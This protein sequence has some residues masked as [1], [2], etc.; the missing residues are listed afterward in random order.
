MAQSCLTLCDP[1]DWSTPGFPVLH[2][3]LE[4]TQ[5]HVHRV[6]DVIQPSYPL[7]SPS[8]A[9]N[10]PS[11]MDF[12][13]ES[14]LHVSILPHHCT[15]VSWLLLLCFCISLPSVIRNYFKLLFGTRGTSRKLNETY[16]LQRRNKGKDLYPGEP[17]RV[18]LGFPVFVEH[19]RHVSADINYWFWWCLVYLC[20]LCVWNKQAS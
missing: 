19:V 18:L 4:L 14:V 11:I 13:S 7:S 9:F 5:N 1:M 17:H 2:Q 12:P 20:I 3:L 6:G 16:F 15:I 8:P 10:L